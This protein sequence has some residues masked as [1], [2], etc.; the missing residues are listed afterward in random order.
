MV[1]ANR[2][3]FVRAFK[4]DDTMLKNVQAVWA[5]VGPEIDR[6]LENF[7]EV[8]QADQETA[9]FFPSPA[10]VAHAKAAQ[11]Q[12][13]TRLFTGGFN[14]DYFD[15]AERVGAIHYK[16]DLPFMSYISGY[17]MACNQM[18]DVL[19]RRSQPMLGKGRRTSVMCQALSTLLFIDIQAVIDAYFRAQSADQTKAFQYMSE[20]IRALSDGNLESRVRNTPDDPFPARFDEIRR[21]YNGLCDTLQSV[22]V[23]IEDSAVRVKE[24]SAEILNSS[25]SLSDKA[26]AQAASLEQ[27]AAALTQLSASVQNTRAHFDSVKAVTAENHAHADRGQNVSEQVQAAMQRIDTSSQEIEEIVRS[28]E[29]ISFQTNLLALNAGVEAAR[30]GE[31]GA[32]FSIVASEVRALA[33]RAATATESI[34]V[35]IDKNRQDIGK[36]VS[37]VGESV[38]ALEK[39]RTSADNVAKEIEGLHKNAGEQALAIREIENTVSHI[40]GTTQHNAHLASELTDHCRG[41]SAQADHLENPFAVFEKATRARV[42]ETAEDLGHQAPKRRAANG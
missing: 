20:A 33:G 8:V 38:S 27:A 36:G 13:W 18:M 17:C 35:L 28:I 3:E 26:Q 1:T 21:V 7:Y 22:F 42:V 40:D 16:I 12:H 15:S 31:S 37:L 4:I 14:G 2:S 39:I 19:V 30:A 9:R 6:V 29:E 34:K 11:K 10:I 24:A 32:G 41:L 5:I 25:E 23:H